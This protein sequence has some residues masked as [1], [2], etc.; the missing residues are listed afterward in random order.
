MKQLEKQ[1]ETNIQS[2]KNIKNN[3]TNITSHNMHAY[4][5]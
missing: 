4:N 2:D 1:P 3:K 5:I